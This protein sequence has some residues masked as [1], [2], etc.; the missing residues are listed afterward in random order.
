MRIYKIQWSIVVMRIGHEITFI[1]GHLAAIQ[2]TAGL[3]IRCRGLG[4]ILGVPH[5]RRRPDS[6]FA[7]IFFNE[8]RRDSS[9]SE[10]RNG[11]VQTSRIT[12]IG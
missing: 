5:V 7:P 12:F 8:L 6:H 11:A 9:G 3:R 10:K 1:L 2:C 4:C